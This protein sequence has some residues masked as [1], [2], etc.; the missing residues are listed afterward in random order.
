M[1]TYGLNTGKKVPAIGFGTWEIKGDDAAHD[2]VLAA[3]EAGYRLIDTARIYGNEKGVGRALRD[4]G[5]PREELF[6]TTKLWNEDQGY[7]RTIKA[8][9]ESLEKLGLDYLDL[10]LI[11]W[12]ATSKR[13]DA[14]KAFEELYANGVIKAAG[15]S[16]YTVDHLQELQSQSDLVPAVNQ[17]EFHLFIYEQQKAVLD[18]CQQ[19]GIL[20]EAY[21]PISRLGSEV[22]PEVQ[23]VATRLGKTP[24]QIVLRW[25]LQHG[26][27]PLP[28]STNPDHIKANMAVFDFELTDEDMAALNT[29]SDGERVTWDPAGMGL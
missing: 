22:P 25:C 21:S 29:L 28:R 14:W 11:H 24:Q 15:V 27:L 7:E 20:L 10:Y 5:I 23:S 4:S 16:N 6:I 3:L 18:Y 17:V 2:A 8:C 12:P 1:Q 26:T 13:H 9:E 19:Q